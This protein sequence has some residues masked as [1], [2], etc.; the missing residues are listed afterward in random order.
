M[1]IGVNTGPVSVEENAL[2]GRTDYFGHTVNVAARLEST[3]KP[4]AVAVPSDLYT[5]ECVACS[6]VVGDAKA[7]DL[8]GVS[9]TTFVPL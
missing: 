1:R 7:L 5:S 6:A 3:C 2:T 8:K 4:G 9:G